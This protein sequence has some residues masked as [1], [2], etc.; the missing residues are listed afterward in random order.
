MITPL[1]GGRK[2]GMRQRKN[3]PRLA[4][5]AWAALF[6][7]VAALVLA[8]NRRTVT[9]NYREAAFL[10][11]LGKDLYAG[12]LGTGH[13]FLYLPQAAILFAPFAWLPLAASEIAWRALSVGAFAIGLRRY[14]SLGGRDSGAELFPLMTAL[15]LPLAFSCFRNGQSTVLIAALMMLAVADLADRRWTRAT[16]WLSLGLALKPLVLVLT[17]LAGALY[18]PMRWRL[19][20]GTAVVFAF[21][22]LFQR[23]G[24][25]MDQYRSCVAGMQVTAALGIESY[26][27]HLFGML[28]VAGVSIPPSVQTGIR[29]V[30]AGGTL[31]LCLLARRRCTAA[32]TGVW[33]YALAACY[34]MLFNPRTEN[35]T[36][37]MLGPA[38][39]VFCGRALLVD[40]RPR[41]A[42]AL[43]LAAVGILGSHQITRWI[44]PPPRSVWLA[45]LACTGFLAFLAFTLVTRKGE[46]GRVEE[47]TPP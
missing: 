43:A 33:L 29:I 19:L 21:P 9:G 40:R 6:A 41:V 47:T 5:L 7:V 37:A 13:G 44:T 27:A 30:A 14:A 17:L 46:P 32:E 34:L 23:P 16:V 2:I 28:K 4:W 3:D 45:P 24:Y 20:A 12:A 31:G 36:Y 15:S 22:F 39:S 38:I 11:F 10:W 18:R 25:V 42:M 26:W 8:G 1:P 35:N